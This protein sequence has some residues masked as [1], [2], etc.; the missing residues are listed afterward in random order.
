M[1]IGCYVVFSL[2]SP[3][4]IYSRDDFPLRVDISLFGESVSL[5]YIQDSLDNT[6]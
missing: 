1:N 5:F 4:D 6:N 2:L 3:L